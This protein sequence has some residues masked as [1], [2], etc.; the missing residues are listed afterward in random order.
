MWTADRTGETFDCAICGGAGTLPDATPAVRAALRCH[1][2]ASWTERHAPG[3]PL[4]EGDDMPGP[5]ELYQLDFQTFAAVNRARCE[6][7]DGFGHPLSGWSVSDWFLAATGEFGEAANKAKKLNRY[8]DGI[9]G[10]TETEE[11]LRAGLAD[12]IADAV[13]YLDLLA[14]SQGFDL[15]SIVASKF[16]RTS[17]KIGAPHRLR[18]SQP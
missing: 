12:E 4:S 1:C 17:A 11:E 18:E 2:N 16:N 3:C 9:P 6:A 5:V 15:G 8:R 14:Q 7:P 10:N 13:I